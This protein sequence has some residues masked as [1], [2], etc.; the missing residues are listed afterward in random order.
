MLQDCF[1]NFSGNITEVAK[2]GYTIISVLKEFP[3]QKGIIHYKSE[4]ANL[5]NKINP[6]LTKKTINLIFH[7]FFI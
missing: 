3:A 4:Q 6:K 7:F 2:I 5:M 1:K